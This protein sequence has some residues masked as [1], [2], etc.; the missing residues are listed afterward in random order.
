MGITDRVSIV[1]N[2]QQISL[3]V[4]KSVITSLQGGMSEVDIAKLL[5][6]E[7]KIRG[8]EEFWYDIPQNVLI[9][10]ERFREGTTITDYEI[11]RPSQEIFLEDGLP[12]FID[13]SPVDPQTKQWGDWSS[14]A[15]FHPRQDLDNEQL[16][17]LEEM[18]QIHRQGLTLI[19][20]EVTGSE[21]ISY[22]LEALNQRG[23]TLLDVRNNVGH[24][25][26]SGA[27]DRAQRIWLDKGNENKLEEGIYAVEVGGFRVRKDGKGA[28]VGRF[29]ECIFVP[30]EGNAILLGINDLAPLII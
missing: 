2:L 19:S 29:E 8:I 23:I 17:F 16:A 4:F 10:V 9:G 11:K 12:V 7:F 14:T 26:H 25:V 15:I 13:L 6:S 24:S 21:I 20:S 1:S 5:K 28:S 27:K 22:Y 18:R 3:N 30:K